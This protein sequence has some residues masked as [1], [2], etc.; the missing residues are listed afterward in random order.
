MNKE[1][2]EC[3]WYGRKM[4]QHDIVNLPHFGI[5][6]CIK[7]KK[8]W[9]IVSKEQE[10]PPLDFVDADYERACEEGWVNQEPKLL[11]ILACRERQLHE[12][13]AQIATLSAQVEKL[14]TENCALY[15]HVAECDLE[16]GGWY[17]SL[18][19]LQRL[20]D[21]GDFETAKNLVNNLIADGCELDHDRLRDKRLSALDG[22]VATAEAELAALREG[23]KGLHKIIEDFWN[24][25]CADKLCGCDAH[26]ECS[27]T[28]HAYQMRKRAMAIE[29]RERILDT[30]GEQ[31]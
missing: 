18:G 5:E 25:Q 4:G 1:A 28:L 11:A 10:L 22:R 20:L 19:G 23:A 27:H 6:R 30:T 15:S 21:K 31:A 12:A 16:F 24:G 29:T 17:A 13:L 7:C 26:P 3:E 9:P 2:D 14:D 8:G